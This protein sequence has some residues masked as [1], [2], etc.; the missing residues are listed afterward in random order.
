ME[1]PKQE[2]VSEIDMDEYVSVS[3][4]QNTS[5]QLTSGTRGKR[6]KE[7]GAIYNDSTKC[8]RPE[9]FLF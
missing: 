8:R 9:V 4:V 6:M 3:V 7:N 2:S 1:R 5:I